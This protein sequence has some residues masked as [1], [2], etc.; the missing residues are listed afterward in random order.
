MNAKVRVWV[1]SRK[2]KGGR[3]AFYARWIDASAGK[4]VNHKL[5][6]EDDGKLVAVTTKKEAKRQADK[7]ED[8]LNAGKTRLAGASWDVF[9]GEA[10]ASKRTERYART[11]RR[12]LRGIRQLRWLR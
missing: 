9:G 8:D 2:L 4:W 6:K 1:S 10:T 7:I 12:T 5:E 3:R 11:F